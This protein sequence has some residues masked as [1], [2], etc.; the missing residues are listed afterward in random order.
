MLG[1]VVSIVLALIGIAVVLALTYYVS[2]WYAGRLSPLGGGR[3][4]KVIDRVATGKSGA[5]ILVELNG[6][7]Y[8]MGV[9]DQGVQI[10]K[11]LEE[12]VPDYATQTAPAFDLRNL[13][14]RDLLVRAGIRKS[15]GL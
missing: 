11:E 1:D 12:P 2:K 9:S 5:L 8:L 7:Q 4:I 6:T 10:L 15:D 13:N 3:H 14:F